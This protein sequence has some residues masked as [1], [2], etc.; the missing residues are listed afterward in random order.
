[1]MLLL[2]IAI[3]SIMGTFLHW[4]ACML[5][6]KAN[7][8]HNMRNDGSIVLF[9]MAWPVFAIMIFAIL[10]VEIDIAKYVHSFYNALFQRIKNFLL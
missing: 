9:M 6:D 1:M 7:A 10:L 2:Y 8:S 5:A 4:I 3:Y